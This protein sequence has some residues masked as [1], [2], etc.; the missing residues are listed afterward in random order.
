MLP[1]VLSIEIGAYEAGRLFK[2]PTDILRYLWYEK[3]GFLQ[4]LE[5]KTL[6]KRARVLYSH[7]WGPLD[8]SCEAK[9][10]DEGKIKIEIQPQGM[11]ASCQMA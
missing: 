9:R 6:I 5:P 11:F 10:G 2:T 1:K 7:I 4:I 3:T 8:Q